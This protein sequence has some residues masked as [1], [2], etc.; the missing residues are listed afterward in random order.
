MPSDTAPTKGQTMSQRLKILAAAFIGLHIP[1]LIVMI[2]AVT[3]RLEQAGLI[4]GLVFAATLV[5]VVATLSLLWMLLPQDHKAK[6][7][8]AA[9]NH[10]QGA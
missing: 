1:L 8:A 3:L 4:V 7:H 10:A 6:D 9:A 2:A 5:A